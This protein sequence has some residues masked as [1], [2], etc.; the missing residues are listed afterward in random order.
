MHG[1]RA[2][3]Y[4][5]VRHGSLRVVD[6]PR[7]GVYSLVEFN[8]Q[9]AAYRFLQRFSRNPNAMSRLEELVD[10]EE[11][12]DDEDEDDEDEEDDEFAG[13]SR[14]LHPMPKRR[15]I[16]AEVAEL[17]ADEEV[18][19]AEEYHRTN[20]PTTLDKKEEIAPIVQPPTPR[21]EKKLTWIEVQVVDDATGKPMNWVRLVV[22]TPDGNQTYQTTNTEGLVRLE[23]L[24]PGTCDISCELK[25]PKAEDVLG[26]AG[27]GEKAASTQ[28]DQEN[29]NGEEQKPGTL[30]IADIERHKVQTGET[31][32]G[33]AK[34][35]GLTWKELAM[36]NWGT[37]KPDEINAALRRFVG[38][39]KRTANGAN[40]KFD[41]SDEPGIVL[42]PRVWKQ[43]SLAT[44]QR[45]VVRVM[46]VKLEPKPFRF[47]V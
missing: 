7:D 35:N 23:E 41:S 31:L 43:E 37:D 16:L 42:I 30:R 18:G 9:S 5:L 15:D 25:N 44:G 38:C 13:R 24:D 14:P 22:R 11:W 8:S 40:Y 17:I 6:Y 29:T 12:D 34:K 32:D 19:V 2:S 28:E 10:D 33:L 21:A 20:P 3:Q 39:T 27:M 46:K 4:I 45:H 36:Y 26:F 1:V 47:S